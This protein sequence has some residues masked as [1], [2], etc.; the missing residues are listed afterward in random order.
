MVPKSQ[1]QGELDRRKIVGVNAETV[2]NVTSTDF[3]GHYPG[4]D[5]TWDLK[6]FTDNFRIQFNKNEPLD[7]CFSLIGIDASIANA[8]RRILLA[9]I[10][11]LAIEHVFVKNNTCIV[12][13]EVLAHRL[14]LV[15]LT[16]NLEGLNWLKYFPKPAE[17]EPDPGAA[18]Y[19]TIILRLNI[20]CTWALEPK[21]RKAENDPAKLYKN[22]HV[23]AKDLT[24]HPV[25]RQNDYFPPGKEIRPVNPDIL[26]AKM[27]PG[28]H[29]KE[30]GIMRRY[31]T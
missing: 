30:F 17:G 13:D 18:D 15:P 21:D 28:Q 25:G 9:E 20:A 22:A 26:L 3:P 12:Q 10:P 19:N 4:E 7:S 8:F 14:G 24:F 1:S 5:H 6:K 29:S 31:C 2:T 27:R 16:G 23:Y 11:T